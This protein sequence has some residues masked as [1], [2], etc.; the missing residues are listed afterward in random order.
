M[1]DKKSV[2]SG[3]DQEDDEAQ[4]INSIKTE[5]VKTLTESE[6]DKFGTFKWIGKEDENKEND[7]RKI[8]EKL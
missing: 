8:I 7:P 4:P 3:G 5:T 1:F 6:T 2:E